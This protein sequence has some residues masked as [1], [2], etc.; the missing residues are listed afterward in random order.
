MSLYNIYCDE[1]C[2]LE[3]AITPDNRYMVLGA[4]SCL[5]EA[6]QQIFQDIKAIKTEHNIGRFAEMKWTKLARGKLD[7]YKALIDYFFTSPDLAFRAIVIDKASLNHG[8]FS[9]EHNEFYY[10]MYWQM[11]E[12]FVDPLHRYRIYLDIKDSRGFI[13]TR[14]L[15]EVLC[16]SKHDFNQNIVERVQEVRSHEIALLQITDILIGAISYANRYPEGGKSPAKEEII[17]LIRKR[18]AGMS[19]KRSTSVGARKFNV[20]CW[21]GRK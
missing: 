15:H 16:H 6:K 11:L 17:A 4:V 12:W 3:Q 19:L 1:S 14:K 5:E 9:Q 10:K 7:A 20:F 8:A 2:H 21:E 18:S 13:K